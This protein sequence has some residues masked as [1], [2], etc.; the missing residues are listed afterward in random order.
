M[1]TS[2][3]EPN[4]ITHFEWEQVNPDKDGCCYI[5]ESEDVGESGKHG[6]FSLTCLELTHG[7]KVEQLLSQ[8][9]SY[10]SDLLLD[11]TELE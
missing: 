3:V 1:T 5:N 10:K 7:A 9:S 2:F 8:S 4:L 11:S 6:A